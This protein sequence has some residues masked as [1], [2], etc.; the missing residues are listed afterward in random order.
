MFP[1]QKIK[2]GIQNPD[3]I[4][5]FLKNLALSKYHNFGSKEMNIYEKN[6]DLLIILDACRVDTMQEVASEYDFLPEK[7]PSKISVGGGSVQW[8]KK[9]FTS[10]WK[11]EIENTT[12]ITANPHS[13]RVLGESTEGLYAQKGGTI[14]RLS[15]FQSFAPVYEHRWDD[16]KG[17]VSPEAV[18][19]E[20]FRLYPD[21]ISDRI[22]IHYMQPHFP[23]IPDNLS[24]GMDIH[25]DAKWENNDIWTLIRRGHVSTERAYEAYKENLKYVLSEVN[26]I[27]TNTNFDRVIITAD[28]GNAFGK[29]GEI[30]HGQMFL[31]ATREVP[32]IVTEAEKI[33]N[34]IPE[35]RNER[36]DDTIESLS[37]EEKLESLGYKV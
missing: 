6:W 9:T 1:I 3:K 26:R 14:D 35:T 18:T 10:E 12:Y 11:H 7:I 29:W 15:W 23:S 13:E 5:R 24:Q 27:L 36:E 33:E 28:H 21:E 31:K 4:P 8:M 32:W 16:E 2:A 17:T 30:A 37:V 19:D 20:F 25:D 22:V 34:N